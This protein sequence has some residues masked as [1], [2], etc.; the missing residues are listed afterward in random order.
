VIGIG[1]AA[2]CAAAPRFHLLSHCKLDL[3]GL[4]TEMIEPL[5]LHREAQARTFERYKGTLLTDQQADHAIMRL[6]KECVIGVQRSI[7]PA[8]AA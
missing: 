2:P 6:Y 3:P 1:N 5:A 8:P 4:V 7:P